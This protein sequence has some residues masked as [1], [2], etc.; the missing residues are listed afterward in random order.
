MEPERG[1]IFLLVYISVSP[2]WS[3]EI[4]FNRNITKLRVIDSF[5]C[6]LIYFENYITHAEKLQLIKLTKILFLHVTIH[7]VG[8]VSLDTKLI[9]A[10]RHRSENVGRVWKIKSVK[11][12]SL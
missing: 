10:L 1:L 3:G 4:Q 5:V 2:Q 11:Y 7:L 9:L 8:C 12:T 6:F